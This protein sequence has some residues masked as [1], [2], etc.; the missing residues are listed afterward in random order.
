MFLIQYWVKLT[1]QNLAN[2]GARG[3]GCFLL[4]AK[5]GANWGGQWFEEDFGIAAALQERFPPW[6]G[7]VGDGSFDKTGFVLKVGVC[8]G[9]EQE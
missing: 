6:R 7:Q 8:L 4:A 9:G 3:K 2:F 5:F 1:S